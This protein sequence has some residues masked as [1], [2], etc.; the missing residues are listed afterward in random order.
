MEN[1]KTSP[2]S[3]WAPNLLHVLVSW[4]PGYHNLCSLVR[5]QFMYI[6]LNWLLEFWSGHPQGFALYPH[7][8]CNL[9]TSFGDK[10]HLQASVSLKAAAPYNNWTFRKE[11][12]QYKFLTRSIFQIFRVQVILLLVPAF[13]SCH[14]L[15][16]SPSDKIFT[17]L[18]KK[19]NAISILNWSRCTD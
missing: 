12:Q 5:L 11:I 13:P 10:H 2:C 3:P 9:A 19:H 7:V 15:P 18:L 17:R 6:Y 8:L 14:T 1:R 4:I 16:H